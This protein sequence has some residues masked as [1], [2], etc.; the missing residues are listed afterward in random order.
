MSAK[1]VWLIGGFFTKPHHLRRHVS[2][3]KNLLGKNTNVSVITYPIHQCAF[4]REKYMRGLYP[5]PPTDENRVAPDIVHTISGGSLVYIM[6]RWHA[7]D[8]FGANHKLVL[9]SAPFFPCPELMS[10]FV[11]Y[12]MGIPQR[13]TPL[14]RDAFQLAWD[15]GGFDQRKYLEN[16]SLILTDPKVT[17]L[18]M[19]GV[20]D[21]T[22][23]LARID[24]LFENDKNT[25]RVSF[26]T[27]I[28]GRL[29]N[30]KGYKAEMEKFLLE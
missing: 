5:S 28:H 21:P 26:D 6:S 17:R 7:T 18:S 14:I 4:F 8:T 15:A 29:I 20:H 2:F 25:R 9:D 3:Y 30:M 22:L 19:V 12:K 10:T 11:G 24:K 1:S 16:T 27:D 13:H 23:D